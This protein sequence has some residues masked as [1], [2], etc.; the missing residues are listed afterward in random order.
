M[1]ICLEEPGTVVKSL[2]G[3]DRGR[4]LMIVRNEGAF[5]WLAD[6]RERKLSSPKKKNA[7]HIAPTKTVIPTEGLTDKALRG[8]LMSFVDKEGC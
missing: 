2:A 8:H 5:V 7:A 4:F 6:G 3:R 1:R